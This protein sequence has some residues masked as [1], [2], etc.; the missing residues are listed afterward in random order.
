MKKLYVNKYNPSSK[1]SH[2]I[3]I[4]WILENPTQEI[5]N[6]PIVPDGNMDIVYNNN[7]LLLVGSLDEGVIMPIEPNTKVFGIRFKPSILSQLLTIKASD[8]VNKIVPLEDVSKELFI[9][10]SF[11]EN[12]EKNKV[13]NLNIIL[14]LFC[15]NVILNQVILKIIDEIM[16][17]KGDVSIKDISQANN[18][19]PRQLERLFNN[20]VGFSPKRFTNIIKFFYAFKSLLKS[21][22]NELSLKALDFGYYD[23]AH[24]NR[25]FKKFSNLTPTDKI[26]SVLYNTK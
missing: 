26:M 19:N 17:K 1:L 24:F 21:D 15:K 6:I 3:D 12:S 25:D 8:F 14:E 16:T 20:L 4:Y 18:I 7:V 11:D 10:L 23:Q 13:K 9:L 22:F 5:V 2:I